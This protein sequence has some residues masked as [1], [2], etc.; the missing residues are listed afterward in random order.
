MMRWLRRLLAPG[1]PGVRM[2]IVDFGGTEV[3]PAS[4]PP[5]A[6]ALTRQCQEHVALAPP[7]GYGLSAT[8]RAVKAK[9]D[10]APDEWL[11]GLFA[12]PDQP[13]ALGYHST[14]ST[15]RPILKI[16]PL[17]DKQDGGDLS[18]TIS[19]EVVEALVDPEGAR[20]AQWKDGKFWALEAA[21]AVEA[22]KYAIDGV[23]VSN[24]V[25]PPYFEPIGASSGVKY[26]HLGLCTKPLE[27]RPG[28]YG[29]WFDPARGWQQVVHQQTAPRPYR[30][31]IPG[32]SRA[33]QSRLETR[34]RG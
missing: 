19:H 21:D 20:A 8:I 2:A 34:P 12:H 6:A 17:L 23:S 30:L 10:M 13:G 11:I 15:G 3:D 9:A 26:D 7:F 24:F 1:S 28:G 16:F 14:T 25:L 27:I 29:Q 33:R 22:D 4:L 32:R 18:V 31:K 5:I